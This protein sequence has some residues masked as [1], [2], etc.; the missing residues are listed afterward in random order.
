MN[1]PDYFGD[2]STNK[3]EL[4]CQQTNEIR[5]PQNN[6]RCVTN[7]NCS[8]LP[9][10]LFGDITAATCVTARNCTAGTFG[11]NNTKKCESDCQG[12][13]LLYADP[14]SKECVDVC[15][16]RYYSLN[17]SVNVGICS[18]TCPLPLWAD[19]IT[20]RCEPQCSPLTYGVNWTDI[21]TPTYFFGTC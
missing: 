14:I 18:L 15:Q 7:T 17:G 19:N 1:S 3:C 6:R 4:S 11:D 20:K 10:A 8:R 13:T 12:P 16:P 2:N 21:I 5:D 9:V